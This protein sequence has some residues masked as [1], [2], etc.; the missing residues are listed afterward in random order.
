MHYA[1][2]AYVVAKNIDYDLGEADALKNIGLAQFY[3][4]QWNESLDNL[5]KALQIIKHSNNDLTRLISIYLNIGLVYDAKGDYSEALSF[6]LNALREAERMK[7]DDKISKVLNNIGLVYYKRQKTKIN[8]AKSLE[9]LYK[10]MMVRKKLNDEKGLGS[11]YYNIGLVY[12]SFADIEKDTV[13]KNLYLDTSL[14]YFDNAIKI[15]EKYKDKRGMATT[16]TNIANIYALKKH[17]DKAREYFNNALKISEEIDDKA[18]ISVV[19]HNIGFLYSTE[20]KYLEAMNYYVNSLNIA[21]NIDYKEIIMKNYEMLSKAYM[22]VS[23]YKKAYEYLY[24]YDSI[25]DSINNKT[26][27]L[28]EIQA[29]YD[30]EKINNEKK[31]LEKEK[32]IQKFLLYS[33]LIGLG[34]LFIVI[35]AIWYAYNQKRKIVVLLKFQHNELAERKIEIE[36]QRDI[37]K[38]K[39]KQILDSIT[40]ANRIQSSILQSIDDVKSMFNDSFVLFKPKDIVSGDFYWSKKIDDKIFIAAVDCTGHGVPGAFMSIIGL[41]LLNNAIYVKKLYKPSDILNS[42]NEDLL[43]T[44]RKNEY[45]QQSKD[46]MDIALCAI[47]L[48]NDKLEYAGAFNPLVMIRNNEINIYKADSHIIGFKFDDFSGYT[49]QEIQ[50]KKGDWFYIFSD[51]YSDQFGGPNKKKFMTK[52]LYQLLLDNCHLSGNEQ[53]NVLL[54]EHDSWRGNNEQID[55]ILVIGFN[56]K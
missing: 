7:D 46:G 25:K 26:Q 37:V 12:F 44:L 17:I 21:I 42:L 52:R 13:T 14:K 56:V 40:Y 8:L 32:Q 27:L 11:S 51:G 43:I 36:K 39:N 45:S 9:Y 4:S 22:E 6:Y 49:N 16:L 38:L 33:T 20:R 34:F 1:K 10:G 55:D 2:R 30:T 47:D 5:N 19:L 23:D 28:A 29:K 54:Q 15:K 18:G 3:K 31:L 48:T 24:K 41:Q 35:I 53:F 50:I